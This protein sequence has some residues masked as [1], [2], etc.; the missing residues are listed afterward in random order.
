MTDF[1]HE[2]SGKPKRILIDQM[3]Y[4]TQQRNGREET[5]QT[6]Y[7]AEDEEGNF[8]ATIIFTD[9]Q[10]TVHGVGDQII[11]MSPL[12]TF[13]DA[14]AGLKWAVNAVHTD[15]LSKPAAPVQDETPEEEIIEEPQDEETPPSDSVS[16]VSQMRNFKK[17]G[18]TAIKGDF[19]QFA[20]KAE[21][22]EPQVGAHS[23]IR[24]TVPSQVSHYL[25]TVETITAS[26]QDLMP[27]LRASSVSVDASVA[28]NHMNIAIEH[29][30]RLK[31]E[32]DSVPPS[33]WEHL[34]EGVD[35]VNKALGHSVRK[36]SEIVID[37]EETPA[38]SLA[39]KIISRS[40]SQ[41]DSEEYSDSE[42]PIDEKTG[43]PEGAL[44]ASL[45]K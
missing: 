40:M 31:A 37:E 19:S 42:H 30:T 13:K 21:S 23:P 45:I 18:T 11:G 2:H 29:F 35:A 10:V 36:Q 17:T 6:T 12:S 20:S 32:I 5:G 24:N 3:P 38:G 14:N 28:I 44:G 43:M 1:I 39:E 9:S 26:M 7:Y 34:Q 22:H 41:R 16:L 25:D 27:T 15:R 8:L 4:F 33:E